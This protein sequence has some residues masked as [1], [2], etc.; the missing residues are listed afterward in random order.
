[1]LARSQCRCPE[2]MIERYRAR[3]SGPLPDRIDL[4]LKVPA[5]RPRRPRGDPA[6]PPRGGDPVPR[7]RPAAHDGR[8][9]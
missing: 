4:H 8:A 9:V 5:L 3:V 2:Q 7:A 6:R 1:M